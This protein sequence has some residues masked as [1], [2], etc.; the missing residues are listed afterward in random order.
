MTEQDI[1]D[2]HPEFLAAVA[3]AEFKPRDYFSEARIEEIFARHAP[4]DVDLGCGDGT[5]LLEMVRR[6]PERNF[7][8]TERQLGRVEK[9]ARKIARAEV[10]N[11]RVLRLENLYALR[12]FLPP[13]CIETCY[14]LFPDPWPKRHHHGRRL[15]QE[16]FMA[17]LRRVLAIGGEV[18][19]KTD[20]LPYYQWMENVWE[21]SPGYERLEWDEEPDWPRTDFEQ[22]FLARGLP[23]YRARLRKV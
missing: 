8:G 2:R 9:V 13:A 21:R 15:I 19:V 14:V 22:L 17:A 16:D 5:F 20:D 10:S 11:A 6:F 12:H 18:R 7:L 4:L 23:I 3:R 1:R